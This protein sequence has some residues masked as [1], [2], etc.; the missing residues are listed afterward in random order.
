MNNPSSI[1]SAPPPVQSAALERLK[2]LVDVA[3][4]FLAVLYLSG[5]SYLYGYYKSFGIGM[6]ELSQPSQP[7]LVFGMIALHAVSHW[8]VIVSIV[9]GFAALEFLSGW[10]PFIATVGY[11]LIALCVSIHCP[12]PLCRQG[13]LWPRGM[14]GRTPTCRM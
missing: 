14:L 12:S 4:I 13:S 10:K 9:V 5:W 3:V 8:M 6:N 1:V 11:L 2:R 7:T